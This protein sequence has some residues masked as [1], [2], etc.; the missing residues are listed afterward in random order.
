MPPSSL[1]TMEYSDIDRRDLP[2]KY[3]LIKSLQQL[4]VLADNFK[5]DDG[6]GHGL[7]SP[8]RAGSKATLHS[9]TP[10]NPMKIRDG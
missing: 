2:G 8:L 6:V 1:P 7:R 3:I 5:V 9:N 10:E 4:Q